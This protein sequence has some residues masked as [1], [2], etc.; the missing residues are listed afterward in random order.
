[1]GND[2]G[3]NKM[4]REHPDWVGPRILVTKPEVAAYVESELARLIDQYKLVS[5]GLT[6]NPYPTSEGPSAT[7]HGFTDNYWRYYEAF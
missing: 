5:T 2:I 4:A 6:Y 3:T 1:M 7:R